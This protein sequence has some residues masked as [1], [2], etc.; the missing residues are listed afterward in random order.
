MTRYMTSLA[1]ESCLQVFPREEM[2][3]ITKAVLEKTR[4]RID[5]LLDGKGTFVRKAITCL[6][7]VG[8]VTDEDGDGQEDAH[9][10]R[11]ALMP[12]NMLLWLYELGN[13]AQESTTLYQSLAIAVRGAQRC[14]ER[15]G[16]T[17]PMDA[18]PVSARVK[19]LIRDWEHELADRKNRQFIQLQAL[20]AALVCSVLG[21][22][23]PPEYFVSNAV[24]RAAPSLLADL[25]Q[26][27]WEGKWVHAY[28][29]AYTQSD[30][31]WNTMLFQVCELGRAILVCKMLVYRA[32]EALTAGDT[33]TRAMPR[34]QLI[35]RLCQ[36]L[37]LSIT[38]MPAWTKD[39]S[40]LGGQ[41]FFW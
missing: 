25:G 22:G 19:T 40:V 21:R 29:T 15:S 20:I 14:S 9:A 12:M 30:P 39:Y 3:H 10:P 8:I 4:K 6:D 11:Y 33:R 2:P 5:E 26:V 18:I 38:R 34:T 36:Y 31:V 17:M 37:K 1:D 27:P 35:A 23:R 28:A 24:Y 32:A 13:N 7:Y 41:K 16:L